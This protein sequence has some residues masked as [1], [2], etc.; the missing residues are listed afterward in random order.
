MRLA[1]VCFVGATVT[2]SVRTAQPEVVSCSLF[3]AATARDSHAVFRVTV[4]G[5]LSEAPGRASG[6]LIAPPGG[7]WGGSYL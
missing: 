1:R 4:Y 3:T 7:G 6:P 2:C 5:P